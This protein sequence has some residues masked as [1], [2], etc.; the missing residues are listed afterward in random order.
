MDPNAALQ[1]ITAALRDN[2]V[3]EAAMVSEDLEAW[4]RAGGFSPAPELLAEFFEAL[5]ANWAALHTR[6]A[7][8]EAFEAALGAAE[9]GPVEDV[10]FET[11]SSGRVILLRG[12]TLTW[13]PMPDNPGYMMG[14]VRDRWKRMLLTDILYPEGEKNLPDLKGVLLEVAR[15]ALAWEKSYQEGPESMERN[16]PYSKSAIGLRLFTC[17]EPYRWL[18]AEAARLA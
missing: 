11:E 7:M 12:L 8:G 15:Q 5:R 1:A 6:P 9:E 2:D 4:F 13:I 16:K 18:L 10:S 17:D 14:I 3:P